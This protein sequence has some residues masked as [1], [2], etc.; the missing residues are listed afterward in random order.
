MSYYSK[1]YQFYNEKIKNIAKQIDSID[2]FNIYNPHTYRGVNISQENFDNL[3]EAK[4]LLEKELNE[5]LIKEEAQ[6]TID[7]IKQKNRIY[8]ATY[9]VDGNLR[10]EFKALIDNK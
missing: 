10:P 7:Y 5:E 4:Q 8:D 2:Q 3:N 6:E 9:D 1:R